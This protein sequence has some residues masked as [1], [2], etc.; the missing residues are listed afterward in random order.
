MLVAL[1]DMGLFG[2]HLSIGSNLI[3]DVLQWFD[4]SQLHLVRGRLLPERTRKRSFEFERAADQQIMKFTQLT[5]AD[6][7]KRFRGRF[8]DAPREAGSRELGDWLRQ[9]HGLWK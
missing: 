2:R 6:F 7:E 1:V 3:G 4:G 9:H 8:P 5:A